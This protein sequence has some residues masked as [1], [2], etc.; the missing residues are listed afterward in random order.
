MSQI[1]CNIIQFFS[2]GTKASLFMGNQHC[3]NGMDIHVN[4]SLSVGRPVQNT[5]ENIKIKMMTPGLKNLALL[6]HL[7]R[8]N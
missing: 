1:N 6:Y 4:S 5:V 2:K 7:M 8:F 3:L